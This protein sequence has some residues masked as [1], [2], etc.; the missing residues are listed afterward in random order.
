MQP[1][2]HEDTKAHEEETPPQSLNTKRTKL[3]HDTHERHETRP[4]FPHTQKNASR[5]SIRAREP[6]SKPQRLRDTELSTR[7]DR[8][9]KP[10]KAGR[11]ACVERTP[12]TQATRASACV[13]DVRSTQGRRYAAATRRGSWQRALRISVPLSLG[14]GSTWSRMQRDSEGRCYRARNGT[15]ISRRT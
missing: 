5:C 4:S 7:R 8:P 9:A 15:T 6:N 11:H 13:P 10:G 2:R 3:D 12:G 14:G 1:R